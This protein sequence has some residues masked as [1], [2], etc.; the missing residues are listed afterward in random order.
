MRRKVPPLNAVKAFEAVARY[1]HL[2]RASEELCV[3]HSALSQQVKHLEEWFG[4]DLFERSAGRMLL[5][6]QGQQ[7]LPACSKA[8]DIL[9]DACLSL[10]ENKPTDRLVIQCEPTFAAKC[11]RGRLQELRNRFNLKDI[12]L[13][14]SHYLPPKFPH[15]VDL[16][17]HYQRH[18]SWRE[19]HTTQ[20]MDLY[21]FPACSPQILKDTEDN[22][23]LDFLR[24]AHLVHGEDRET[25]A[26]WL[27]RYKVEGIDSNSGT[28]YEDFSLAIE[29]AVEG[30]GVI[31]AD[32]LFCKKELDSGLLTP[33]SDKK[34]FCV[35]YYIAS[36]NAVYQRPLIQQ[37]HQWVL[38]TYSPLEKSA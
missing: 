21:G 8:M 24:N 19:I 7:L 35:S 1:E 36:M 9:H 16:L 29:A 31:I 34:V 25:W 6:E 5:T 2:G 27:T 20:L 13:V 23:I 28:L 22:H 3:S 37:L 33:I 18:P 4:L 15:R 26:A 14:T 11:L 12:E 30:E 17:I 38:D 10:Q 32:P